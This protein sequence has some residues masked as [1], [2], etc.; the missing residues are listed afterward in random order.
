ME[1]KIIL[2]PLNFS[3]DQCGHL[4]NIIDEVDLFLAISGKYW[5]DN[6]KKS[7]FRHWSYKIKRIDMAIKC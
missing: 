7:I 5:F 1:K 6:L 4:L 3:L 2:Q